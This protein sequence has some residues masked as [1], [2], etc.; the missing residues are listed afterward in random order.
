MIKQN[1]IRFNSFG[2]LDGMVGWWDSGLVGLLVG[3]WV[4][5]SQ[6]VV[7]AHLGL[8]VVCWIYM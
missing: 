5:E 7:H 1:A 8:V 4:D 6:E 3:R 2:L